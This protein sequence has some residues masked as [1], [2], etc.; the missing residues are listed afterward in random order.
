MS[1]FWCDMLGH[2]LFHY[3]S[4]SYGPHVRTFVDPYTGKTHI[5]CWRCAEDCG[6]L[7]GV[8]EHDTTT[9]GAK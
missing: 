3:W 6:P 5:R 2:D 1:G 8:T 7:M 4:G 9:G